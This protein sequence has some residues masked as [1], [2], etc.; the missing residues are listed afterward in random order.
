MEQENDL[1]VQCLLLATHPPPPPEPIIKADLLGLMICLVMHSSGAVLM[2]MGGVG[3]KAVTISFS[4]GFVNHG[5]S[6]D[7]TSNFKLPEKR[8]E[9]QRIARGNCFT[10][11]WF[12]SPRPA[13]AFHCM[14][15]EKGCC[16]SRLPFLLY[17]CL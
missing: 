4:K 13:P 11:A 9:K 17:S 8:M 14:S 3:R 2:L 16:R 5:I 1:E 10:F 15:C 6:A 12:V 7:L